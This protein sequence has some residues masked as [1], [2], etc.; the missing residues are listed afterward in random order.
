MIIDKKAMG[1]QWHYNPAHTIRQCTSQT[2]ADF[3]PQM[4]DLAIFFFESIRTK[5]E[6]K[7]VLTRAKPC[8]L[9]GETY[10]TNQAEHSCENQNLRPKDS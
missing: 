7:S 10:T 8:K 9:L 6:Q 3:I 5:H 4:L 2:H 1:E